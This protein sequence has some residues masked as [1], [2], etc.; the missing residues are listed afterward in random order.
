MVN[1]KKSFVKERFNRAYNL[2]IKSKNF[3]FFSVFLLLFT[4]LIGFVFP[5]LFE[6]QITEIIRKM[7]LDIQ[8]K[9]TSELIVYI[10]LNNIRASFFA[11][12]LGI[13][14]GFFPFLTTIIN[15]YVIGFA[16]NLAVATAGPFVLWKLLPHGIF[17]IPAIILSI[18]IGFFLG[19]KLIERYF[20]FKN[21][22]WKITLIS[23]LSLILAPFGIF[24]YFFS[25]KIIEGGIGSIYSL[26]TLEIFM[27]FIMFLVNILILIGF[28]CVLYLFLTDKKLKEDLIDALWVFVLIIFPLILIAGI[29]EGFLI[30]LFN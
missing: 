5:G 7:I 26:T 29:V 21:D 3:I 14:F 4:S 19:A 2:I 6:E 22:F 30:G 27:F 9:T 1:K 28:F 12:I 17:E 13:F 24:Y 23:L 18:G 15:G 11:M 16:S 20:N 8:G 10:F 25:N